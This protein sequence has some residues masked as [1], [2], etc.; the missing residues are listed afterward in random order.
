MTIEE[1][2][3]KYSDFQKEWNKNLKRKA[4]IYAKGTKP[5]WELPEDIRHKIKKQTKPAVPSVIANVIAET[6]TVE[7][8]KE[9]QFEINDKIEEVNEYI[10]TFPTIELKKESILE[11]LTV[12]RL[13][14]TEN[15][16]YRIGHIAGYPK[17]VFSEE[18]VDQLLLEVTKESIQKIMRNVNF[19]PELEY[20]YYDLELAEDL[21][22]LYYYN[23][24]MIELE[25]LTIK[26]NN[27]TKEVILENK[28]D[29]LNHKIMQATNINEYPLV[30]EDVKAYLLFLYCMKSY[31]K[32]TKVL[33]SKYFEIFEKKNYIIDNCC[34]ESFYACIHKEI[35][36]DFSSPM[37]RIESFTSSDSPERNQFENLES[38]FFS[39]TQH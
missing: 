35:N 21:H 25:I 29:E 33:V 30:F 26:Y 18:V 19:R 2:H 20:G 9:F 38:N 12:I 31:K 37:I 28:S 14:L 11:R 36:P 24:L 15:G 4:V 13:A 22:L 23:Q 16:L 39:E 32:I 34:M 8:I 3:S 27:L 17:S 5:N 1:I 10:Y 7:I 6:I